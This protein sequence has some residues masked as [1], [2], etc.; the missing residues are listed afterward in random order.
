MSHGVLVT[1][2]REKSGALI[3]AKYALDF[4]RDVYAL[5]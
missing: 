3:T 2:A 4:G 1:E 5:P